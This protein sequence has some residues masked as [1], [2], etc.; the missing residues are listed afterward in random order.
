MSAMI[1]TNSDQQPLRVAIGGFGTVGG[2]VARRLDQGIDGLTLTA[3]SARDRQRAKDRMRDFGHMVPVLPLE[4]LAKVADVIVECAPAAVFAQLARPVLSAGK[5]LMPITVSALLENWDLVEF[6]KTHG[7][8]IIVPTGALLGLDAV[9]AA[10]EGHIESVRMVTRKPPAGLAGAPYLVEQGIDLAGLAQPLKVFDGNARD[11]AHHFPANVNVAA[12]L[13]LAGIGPDRTQLEIWAD[14]TV[15][16]NTHHV[17][18]NAD[19]ARFELKIENIPS[20]G[21]PR[22]GKIVALSIIAALRKLVSSLC[23]GT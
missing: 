16:R 11:G 17:I 13:G 18:V 19:S 15:T 7:A 20:P 21:N 22:T 9:Q 5:L 12:V 23:V 6:A 8:R 1:T 3:V 4:E 2:V 10:A 14:P